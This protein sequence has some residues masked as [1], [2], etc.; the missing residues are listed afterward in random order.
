M[1]SSIAQRSLFALAALAAFVALLAT[2]DVG[3]T[4][5]SPYYTLCLDDS[6]TGTFPP[7]QGQACDGNA[8]TDA[9]SDARTTFGLTAPQPNFGGTISYTPA[10]LL[11]TPKIAL[12]AIVG[13]LWS[14]ATLGLINNACQN[15]IIVDFTFFYSSIDPT[16]TID[17][18]PFGQ[19]N[20]LEPLAK[21]ADQNGLPDAVDKYPTYL[22]KAFDP[23]YDKGPNGKYE[24][25]S[26][27][28]YDDVP[29][30][31]PPIKPIAR[32]T[33]FTVPAGTNVNVVLVFMLFA[34]GTDL[35]TLINPDAPASA[36]ILGYPSVTVLQDPTTPP[37]PSAITDFCSPLDVAGYNFAISRDNPCTPAPGPSGCPSQPPFTVPFTL[38]TAETC[39]STNAVPDPD[40]NEAGCPT[41][42][43][44]SAAGT[45]TFNIFTRSQRDADG[46]NHENSLDTCNDVPNPSFNPRFTDAANDPD[47][48]G[49]PGGG[50]EGGCDPF[51]TQASQGS[52]NHCIG[53]TYGGDEDQD[54][55][56]NR[57]DN[58]PIIFNDTQLDL[59]IDSIGDVCDANPATDD[60]HNHDLCTPVEITFGPSGSSAGAVGAAYPAPCT[61]AP[62][63]QGPTDA[64]GDGV[65]DGTDQC[66]NT[67]AG[68]TV[69]AIGCTPAQLVLDDDKDGVL[70]ASDKCSGTAPAAKVD[71]K[72]CS[73][74]QN[75]VTGPGAATPA[76]CV[77]PNCPIGGGDPGI[78]S[79]SPIAG[80]L[81]A[82]ATILAGLSGAGIIGGLGIIGSRFARRRE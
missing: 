49:I 20:V 36:E 72:G 81:P 61:V 28:G 48:D 74:V 75:K 10:A 24:K 7:S 44:P 13:K 29:G 1:I 47:T 50:P 8:A 76:P 43:N 71:A 26:D 9:F 38:D 78:G 46:D 67:P 77:G 56:P 34:P 73:D 16:D 12:G 23:D 80:S 32:A 39:D 25:P 55:Y 41:R 22:A 66:A 57:G 45:Y 52:G 19:Q 69:D 59:D 37:A 62:G 30:P 65:P 54:C 63:K 27:P 21:D 6:T 70:N 15:P 40:N 79:L 68:S 11:G 82:W 5:F 42:R 35:A 18:K 60:G 3:A 17:P 31:K 2:D 53:G 51:P 33:G 64:D 4:D 14:R 58:C